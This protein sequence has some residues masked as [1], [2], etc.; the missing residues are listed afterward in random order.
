MFCT[1]DPASREH[2]HRQ[3][4]ANLD[5]TVIRTSAL[6]VQGPDSTTPHRPS[7]PFKACTVA[8]ISLFL[9]SWRAAD[10]SLASG[11]STSS[12]QTLTAT[13]R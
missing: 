13:P 8:T 4:L 11:A 1:L 9:V 2:A 5:A 6:T 7:V 3:S 12:D 10:V